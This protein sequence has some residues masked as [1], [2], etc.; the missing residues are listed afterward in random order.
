MRVHR[1]AHLLAA[2]LLVFGCHSSVQAGLSNARSIQRGP[3]TRATHD[4]I[5]D[6]PESC[7]KTQHKAWRP[8][9]PYC[10]ENPKGN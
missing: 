1:W 6:G 2:A 9:G 7:N 8:Q 10:A 4:S 5:A 3:R